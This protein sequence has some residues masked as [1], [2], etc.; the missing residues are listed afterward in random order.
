MDYRALNKFRYY[1]G[2]TAVTV[3]MDDGQL[4]A[5]GIAVCSYKDTFNL[6]VGDEFSYSRALEA[7]E[8]QCSRES[9]L[10]KVA[11]DEYLRMQ[12]IYL[13]NHGYKYFSEYS[14]CS[15]QGS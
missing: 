11:R 4:L 9:L 6:Q 12:Y 14:Q 8:K 1:I 10:K 3:I 13:I 7:C 5:R 2:T 15:C